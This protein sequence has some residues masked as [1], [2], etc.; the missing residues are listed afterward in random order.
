MT[1]CTVVCELLCF[2]QHYLGRTTVNE[3]RFALL[4]FYSNEAISEAKAMLCSHLVD[5]LPPM[6]NRKAPQSRGGKSQ[7]EKECDDIMNGL[8][9]VTAK[10]SGNGQPV[11]VLF[12]AADL[13]MLPQIRPGELNPL[14]LLDRI[15][16]L[17]HAVAKLSKAP[18]QLTMQPPPLQPPPPSLPPGPANKQP[19]RT[20]KGSSRSRSGQRQ[21][22]PGAG[23]QG[24]PPQNDSAAS[25]V[26]PTQGS[27]AAIS[28][29]YGPTGP[30][31][32]LPGAQLG[33]DGYQDAGYN[34]RKRKDRPKAIMGTRKNTTTTFGPKRTEVFAFGVN[35]SVTE[36]VFKKDIEKDDVTV[37]E[38]ERISPDD[39]ASHYYRILL[40]SNNLDVVFKADFW[41]ENIGC[42]PFRRSRKKSQS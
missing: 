39:S 25:A 31:R 27:Y 10:Y 18:A 23:A 36:A 35:P 33:A 3:L 20:Q 30:P 13:R 42:R 34:R 2:V 41:P 8:Q 9:E 21:P 32:Q 37:R 1:G 19:P 22:V 15:T 5:D 24:Q 11:P 29:Q 12:A 14:M 7:K 26:P 6:K 40:E 17:E 16:A 4:E 28:G 38:M